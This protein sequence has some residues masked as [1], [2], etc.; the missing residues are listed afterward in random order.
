MPCGPWGQIQAKH[1]TY[2][3]SLNPPQNSINSGS[4]LPPFC[5]GGIWGFQMLNHLPQMRYLR[6]LKLPSLVQKTIPIRLWPNHMV[7]TV[8]RPHEWM[9]RAHDVF[10]TKP[11]ILSIHKARRIHSQEARRAKRKM[12]TIRWPGAIPDEKPGHKRHPPSPKETPTQGMMAPDVYLMALKSCPRHLDCEQWP[13]MKT[14]PPSPAP[15]LFLVAQLGKNPPAIWESW[16]WSLG[17]ED[18]L[19]KGKATHSS[20]LAWRIPQFMES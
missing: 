7:P 13:E 6:E 11:C 14:P 16:V 4:S 2:I 20:I 3:I 18:P 15:R 10:N 1:F 9:N 17:W 8:L 12:K 5:T 19:E